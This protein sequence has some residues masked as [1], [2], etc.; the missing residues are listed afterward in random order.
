MNALRMLGKRL[1]LLVGLLLIALAFLQP[2]HATLSRWVERLGI[3]LSV[4]VAPRPPGPE[5]RSATDPAPDAPAPSVAPR[6]DAPPSV[7]ERSPRETLPGGT[8]RERSGEADEGL[9]AP[10]SL[11]ESF[12]ARVAVVRDGDTLDLLTADGRK[13]RVRLHGIDAPEFGQ[14]FH[15]EST[16]FVR[17][18]IGG[19]RVR[20]ERVDV[21]QFDRLIGQ[22]W[23]ADQRFNAEIVRAGWAWRYRQYA[24]DDAELAAAEAQARD[25]KRG[26][27]A[28]PRPLPPW[29]WRRQNRR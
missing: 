29:V 17:D 27:W 11:P 9:V 14:R 15:R 25:A 4:W 18:R 12:E 10:G 7:P 3:A 20:V 8:S 13:V 24:P 19:R 6:G 16:E 28:D 1:L 2:D 22:V 23:F 26:L 21:D 5:S